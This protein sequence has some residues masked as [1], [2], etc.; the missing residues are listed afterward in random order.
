[1]GGYMLEN[2]GVFQ[3]RPVILH[4]GYA[5]DKI[6]DPAVQQLAQRLFQD[7]VVK[8]VSS[9]NDNPSKRVDIL[10]DDEYGLYL[11]ITPVEQDND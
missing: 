3:T 9:L 8:M 7:G 4:Q 6:Q 1:M 10:V 11:I 2:E 5:I